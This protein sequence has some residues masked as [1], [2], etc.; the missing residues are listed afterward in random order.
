MPACQFWPTEERP[1]LD[2]WVGEGVN[3]VAITLP[4][5]TCEQLAFSE[6]NL[7]TPRR[8]YQHITS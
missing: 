7:G 8:A 3:P 6:G 5:K 4:T 2:P 1:S